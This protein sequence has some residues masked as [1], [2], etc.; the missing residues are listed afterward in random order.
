LRSKPDSQKAAVQLLV[1]RFLGL[2]AALLVAA[3]SRT[4]RVFG[5]R[6][7]AAAAFLL[8]IVF[9]VFIATALDGRFAAGRAGTN[10]P[11]GKD[12]AKPCA[13]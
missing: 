10:R 13:M 2:R 3:F 6:T 5:A 9:F 4:L 12:S 11:A 7:L 8:G 1:A